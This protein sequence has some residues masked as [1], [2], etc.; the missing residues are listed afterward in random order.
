MNE[1]KDAIRDAR[2][3]GVPKMLLLGLQHMFAMFGATILVPILVNSYFEGEGLSVQVTLICAGLGTLFFHLCTKLKVPAFLG[4]SFAFLGGFS[5]I[6]QLDTGIFA[7]MT[8]GEK[9][10]YACGGIVVAGALYLILALVIKVVGVKKVMR[11]LPPV[12]TGP[13]IICIGLSLASSAVNNASTNWILALIALAVIIIFNI[14]GKGMF[15][16]IPILLGVVI[17]YAA[18]LIMQAA[19][20]TNPDGSAILNFTEVASASWVGLPPFQLCKFN[21]TAILVMAPIAL[22]TMMEHIGDMSAISAT[23]GENF[24]EDPGLHRT[25]IGDGLAT[26]FAGMVGGP[27]NTTYGENTGVLE[28]SRVHDPRVIRIAA[29]FAVILS[30]IPKMAEIIGSMP[31]AIIGGVSFMLYGMISAIGV[32]NVVENHVDF[33]K[34]RNLIIAAVILVSGLGFSNGLTFTIAGTSITL[35]GL[36]IAALAGIILNA[37]LPGKDYHFG[38]DP[39][40]DANRGLDM[41]PIQEEDIQ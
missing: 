38:D 36:A 41:N 18:A 37:I 12:V 14:W 33:T 26:A 30:F 7:D 22:A 19:G 4:S 11:F 2:T 31:S 28:L 29:V 21:L 9:L 13:I 24:I 5:T 40:A 16:I 39:K 3:L 34:S 6:A 10:P 25:L 15:R 20:L 23:V 1:R 17:S 27:A 35:T 8:M 32:R